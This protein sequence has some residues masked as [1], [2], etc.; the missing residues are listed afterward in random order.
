MQD[1]SFIVSPKTSALSHN[2][3]ASANRSRK[4]CRAQANDKRD[5]RMNGLFLGRSAV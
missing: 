4:D 1:I 3:P 2:K 5:I